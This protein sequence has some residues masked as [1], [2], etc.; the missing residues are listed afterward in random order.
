VEE[1]G[2]EVNFQKGQVFIRTKGDSPNTALR[3]GVRDGNLYSLQG[4]PVQ[5]LM[6][7]SE[8]MC[9]MWHR[10][11]GHLHHRALPLLRQ[12]VIGLPNFSLNHQG[13][14]GGCALGK[15][16]KASFPSSETRSKGILDPIHSDVGGPMPIASV[17]GASY[18]VTII[19][20]FSRKT[21]IYF[22]KTKDEV[23]IHFREFK[24][25]VENM[26]GRKIKVL[27]T[28]PPM[29]SLIS[30]RRQGSRGGRQWPTTRSR[31][32]LQ[33]GRTSLSLVRRRP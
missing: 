32:G 20:D 26:T 10:R 13:V 33:R 7:A 8:S 15:N 14:Y 24:A 22:M 28:T 2:Y 12:M 17:K 6:Q 25:Q 9:E 3:I 27:R 11:M 5:A 29:S 19:D 31:M 30:A 23:F 16:V 4:Q 1:K 18:Y 21:W